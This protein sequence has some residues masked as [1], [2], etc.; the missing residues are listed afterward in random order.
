MERVVPKMNPYTPPVIESPMPSRLDVCEEAKRLTYW[1]AV[2][3]IA[4]GALITG[5]Y[6]FAICVEVYQRGL[7]VSEP[8]TAYLLFLLAPLLIWCGVKLKRLESRKMSYLG[9]AL[10]FFLFVPLGLFVCIWAIAS[11]KHTIVREAFKM[12]EIA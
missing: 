2:L 4:Q 9:A 11:L 5:L 6:A 8:N 3:M 1:P 12:L 10:S 7:R